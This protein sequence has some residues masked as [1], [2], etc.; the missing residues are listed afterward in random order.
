VESHWLQAHDHAD[1]DASGF[2]SGQ[3]RRE[4]ASWFVD[5]FVLGR[6][7]KIDKEITSPSKVAISGLLSATGRALVYLLISLLIAGSL[8]SMFETAHFLQGEMNQILG[9]VLIV[10][11]LFVLGIIRLPGLE[12]GLTQKLG[13]RIAAIWGLGPL[14]LGV[15]FAMAFCPVSAGLFF[16]S[17]IPLPVGSASTLLVPALYGIGSAIPVLGFSIL[18][19]TSIKSIAGAFG[20]L[21]VIEKWAR[22]VSGAVL[23]AVGMY[24]SYRYRL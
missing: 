4:K 5:H 3:E 21:S 18:L 24:L 1:D 12:L 20:K 8:I 10:A 2:W 23:L 11:G 17:L 14:F 13:D 7:R 19:V 22:E 6:R 9:P 16:G 15:L